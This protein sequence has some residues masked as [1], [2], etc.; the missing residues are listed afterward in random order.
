MSA[1]N[2]DFGDEDMQ[3]RSL[4]P[5]GESNGVGFRPLT[6]LPYSSNHLGTHSG[7]ISDGGAWNARRSWMSQPE[8]Q[9]NF[10]FWLTSVF[11]PFVWKIKIIPHLNKVLRFQEHSFQGKKEFWKSV[12]KQEVTSFEFEFLSH[13]AVIYF[14]YPK[15]KK[16]LALLCSGNNC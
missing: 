8:S 4:N 1:V 10:D 2:G 16:K 6:S 15:V 11:K 7:Y 9:S 14:P 13:L 12:R 3:P 5:R